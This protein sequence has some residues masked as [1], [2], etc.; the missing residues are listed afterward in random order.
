MLGFYFVM[1]LMW[2]ASAM[3]VSGTV[4]DKSSREALFQVIV[5]SDV[6]S[7]FFVVT[8]EKGMFSSDKFP[9]N[10]KNVIAHV[11]GYDTQTVPVGKNMTIFLNSV[12]VLDEAVVIG[13]RQKIIDQG[14]YTREYNHD[15]E[16]CVVTQCY[17]GWRLV[18]SGA[19]ARCEKI[20]AV[21]DVAPGQKKFRTPEM[22]ASAERISDLM[23][24]IKFAS[25]GMDASVWK[26]RDGDFNTARLVSD[27][28]AGGVL[29]M[30][31]GLITNKVMK[32]NQVKGGFEDIKCA[33]DGQV[34]AVWGDEFVV[35]RQ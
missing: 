29:G 4:Y 22:D 7:K 28:V 24:K 14:I 18:G 33:I 9:D 1:L 32:K 21:T 16:T 27:S 26:D 20:S 10:T 25:S 2:G 12:N 34:V 15:L 17:D 8:D 30:A 11:V 6:D 19:D 23:E 31:G 13:C 35:G 5:K 3:T